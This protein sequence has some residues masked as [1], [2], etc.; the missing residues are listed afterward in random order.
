MGFFDKLFGRGGRFAGRRPGRS[1]GV[2]STGR[3][4]I[5]PIPIPSSGMPGFGGGPPDVPT[6]YDFNREFE[7]NPE[8]QSPAFSDRTVGNAD[9]FGFEPDATVDV[10][11]DVFSTWLRRVRFSWRHPLHGGPPL[12]LPS[13]PK[14]DRLGWL[15][16][17]FLDLSVIVYNVP[18]KYAVF[19]DLINSSS[20]GQYIHHASS[21]LYTTPYTEI[22]GARRKVTQAM[23]NARDPNRGNLKYRGRKRK[24]PRL[25]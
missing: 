24:P 7:E 22:S 12:S 25:P 10:W 21:H 4:G 14:N 2:P 3:G 20:K 1:G 11:Y 18:Q 5:P 23:R 15:Q 16:V 9:E 8:R 17:E 13:T 19:D 6:G